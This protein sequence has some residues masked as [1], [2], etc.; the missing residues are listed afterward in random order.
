ME[1]VERGSFGAYI[2]C[3]PEKTE[4]ALRMMREEFEKLVQDKVSNDELERAQRYLV[5]RHDID[6]QR[7][8]AIASSLIY[9]DIYDLDAQETFR[10]A[11]K[12]FAVTAQDVQ[13]VAE[14][15]FTQPEVISVV[16]PVDIK[17]T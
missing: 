3:S 12:Y 13:R 16:G 10:A 8:S 2:G 6:L 11:E 17:V 9:E 5:G 4:K 14:R 15:I 7:T 1:G